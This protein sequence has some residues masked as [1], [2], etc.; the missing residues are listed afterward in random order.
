MRVRELHPWDLGPQEAMR[1]QAE[2]SRKVV[3]SGG[4][5]QVRY[6]AGADLAFLGSSRVGGTARAAVVLLSCP[7]LEPVAQ[8]V[9][10]APVTFPYIPGLLAFREA[11]ALARAFAR[12]EPPPDLVL[13]D[14]H[15]LSHPRR[16]GIA[17]H[18]G[19]LLEVPTIGC[20]K[21]RLVGQ[22]GPVP[23]EAGAWTELHD[24]GEVIG[25]VVRTKA[26]AQ[27]VYVSP[28]HLIGLEEAARWTLALC[29][30]HR[31]PEPTRLADLLSKGRLPPAA[32]QQPRLL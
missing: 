27:P 8:V 24:G 15:G 32:G 11:P 20:A 4:P 31:L 3:L 14:G 23:E 9:E 10:E 28:G 6:V 2:L 16:F 18:L 30:G 19:L 13:V 12:L 25:L 21:S 7:E 22:H 1:L 26:G 17:C 29:R 5:A